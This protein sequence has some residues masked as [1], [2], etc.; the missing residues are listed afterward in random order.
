M[1]S[2]WYAICPYFFLLTTRSAFKKARSYVA[3]DACAHSRHL[4]KSAILWWYISYVFIIST[5]SSY[6]SFPSGLIA[7][8]AKANRPLILC[9]RLKWMCTSLLLLH[10]QHRLLWARFWSF[11]FWIARPCP[12][13]S[14]TFVLGRWFAVSHP[15]PMEHLDT[16]PKKNSSLS[17]YIKKCTMGSKSFLLCNVSFHIR[18]QPL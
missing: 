16:Q 2:T 13:E 3:L 15:V 12:I 11:F 6:Y 8:F 5:H 9:N 17:R 10:R 14:L 1:P 18:L 7:G 4:A